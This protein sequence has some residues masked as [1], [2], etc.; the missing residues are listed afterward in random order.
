LVHNNFHRRDV[1]RTELLRRSNLPVPDLCI[2]ICAA[3]RPPHTTATHDAHE[4]AP[5]FLRIRRARHGLRERAIVLQFCIAHAFVPLE[6]R[7]D[8]VGTWRSGDERDLVLRP[9]GKFSM[10]SS[11]CCWDVDRRRLL[12]GPLFY[13][14][15]LPPCRRALAIDP[16]STIT[17]A[18]VTSRR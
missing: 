8:L 11:S 14:R 13:V 1:D 4:I 18:E 6:A 3:T 17:S 5:T 7:K 16:D 15:G 12:L 2:S 10:G 9:D